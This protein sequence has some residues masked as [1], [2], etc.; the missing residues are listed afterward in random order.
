MAHRMCAGRSEP[1]RD[2]EWHFVWRGPD[3]TVRCRLPLCAGAGCRCRNP[4]L[5]VRLPGIRM[6]CGTAAAPAPRGRAQAPPRAATLRRNPHAD[7][8]M[9]F[10]N[11]FCLVMRMTQL[12]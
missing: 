1:S 2:R 11:G 6:D 4:S 8:A 10:V 9:D 3:E 12:I 5:R 7:F